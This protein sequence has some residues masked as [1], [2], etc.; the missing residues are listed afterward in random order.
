MA[1]SFAEDCLTESSDLKILSVN[2]LS[3]HSKQ[4][5]TSEAVS[6][7][8]GSGSEVRDLTVKVINLLSSTELPLNTPESGRSPTQA[9]QL[10]QKPK[11]ISKLSKEFHPTIK[12]APLE[13]SF[14]TICQSHTV[15]TPYLDYS[16]I[17]AMHPG[18]ATISHIEQLS[19]DIDRPVPSRHSHFRI[20]FFTY[21][22]R[23]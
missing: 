7:S 6:T 19:V 8:G 20:A 4:F 2:K 15:S 14:H 9:I 21:P 3:K 17:L 10:T 23:D 12:T 11:L 13:S 22:G 1:N 18:P 16:S 5:I